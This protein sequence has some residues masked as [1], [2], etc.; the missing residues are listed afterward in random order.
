MTTLPTIKKLRRTGS[1]LLHTA[2]TS[3]HIGVPGM[4]LHFGTAL[5]DDLLCTAVLRELT[6]RGKKNIWIMSEHPELFERNSDVAKVIAID[7]YYSQG[8]ELIGSRYKMLQYGRV[9]LATDRTRPPQR[10][11]IAELCGCADIQGEISLRPYFHID[12]RVRAQAAQGSD[13]V[14]IQ[15]SGLGARWPTANKDWYPERFQSV[16]NELG[17]ECKFVQIGSPTDPK[18]EGACDLRGQTTIHEAAALLANSRLYLGGE[19][20]LMHLARAVECPSVILFGGRVAPWQCGY[21]CNTNLFSAVPCAPCWLWQTCDHERRCMREISVAAVVEAV[22]QR[23]AAPREP[24]A[25]D[26]DRL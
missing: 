9:D 18:L 22:R 21:S 26:I 23:L 5:G 20:F 19:G 16:V 6:K 3:A 11:V 15:S 2:K 8:L 4:L 13:V 10:H 24:L 25:V 1:V 7:E 12:E 14:T 17:K